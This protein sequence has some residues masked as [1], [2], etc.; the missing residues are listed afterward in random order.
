[1]GVITTEALNARLYRG[2][3]GLSDLRRSLRT[4]RLIVRVV[5]A[6]AAST[7][8]GRRH[9]SVINDDGR[10][11][12]Q[13]LSTREKAARTTQQSFNLFVIIAGALGTVSLQP[14]FTT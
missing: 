1:M 9:V 3:R 4:P 12:W 7:N 5:A 14:T 11:D 8:P 13:N 10:I 6:R 2:A